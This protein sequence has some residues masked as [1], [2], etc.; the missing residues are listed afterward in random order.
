MPMIG[1]KSPLFDEGAVL[2]DV[3]R[4]ACRRGSRG[5]R[6]RDL[7]VSAVVAPGASGVS[8]R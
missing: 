2:D 4:R 6:A 7:K 3:G 8:K 1:A 5:A